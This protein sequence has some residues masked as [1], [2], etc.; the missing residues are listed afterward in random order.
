VADDK[1]EGAAAAVVVIDN[2]GQVLVSRPTQI[3]E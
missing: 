2:N 1:Y 3:G